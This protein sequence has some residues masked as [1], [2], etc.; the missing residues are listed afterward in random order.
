MN[1]RVNITSSVLRDKITLQ[2]YDEAG[3]LQTDCALL[4][5]V[6]SSYSIY[7]IDANGRMMSEDTGR[8]NGSYHRDSDFRNTDRM[9]VYYKGS[10]YHYDVKTQTYT[11]NG[12]NVID[13]ATIKALDYNRRIALGELTPSMSS[14]VWDYYILETGEHPKAIKVHK[15]DKRVVEATEEEAQKML[16]TINKEAEARVREEAAKKQLEQTEEERVRGA[17]QQSVSDVDLGDEAAMISQQTEQEN[18]VA[19]NSEKEKKEK[20]EEAPA[21]PQRHDRDYYADKSVEGRQGYKATTD[22]TQTFEELTRD[23]EW[24]YKIF[25]LLSD[26]FEDSPIKMDDKGKIVKSAKRD[27]LTQ[28]LKEKKIEVDAIGTSKADIDAWLKTIEECR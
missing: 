24:K 14:T 1:P 13:E 27:V 23:R 17:E 28:F 22:T 25:Q 21:E 5:T 18:S 12:I 15:N 6:G 9:Q 20:E 4:H 10:P 2:E 11:L 16:D 8:N 3:A 7:A 26:K 19:E